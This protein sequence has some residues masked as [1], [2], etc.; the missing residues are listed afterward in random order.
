MQGFDWTKKDYLNFIKAMC[1]VG[2][3]EIE[4][5]A[6]LLEKNEEEVKKY[7]KVF[8][9][10]FTEIPDHEKI[11]NQ[12]EKAQE[13]ILKNTLLKSIYLKLKEDN[14]FSIAL[15]TNT[16]SKFYPE[17]VDQF[18]IEKYIEYCDKSDPGLAIFIDL[19]KCSFLRF[20]YFILSRN[21]I[22]IMRRINTLINGLLREELKKEKSVLK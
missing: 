20:N 18:L 15:A 12:L 22:D 2:K 21:T 11:R 1:T 6:I 13:Q 5:I 17:Y 8:W 14:N 19:H 4:K 3:N 9:E 10:R 16:R 7:H